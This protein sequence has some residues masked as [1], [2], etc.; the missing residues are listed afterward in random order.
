MPTFVAKGGAGDRFLGPFRFLG[1]L[2][3]LRYPAPRVDR[4]FKDGYTVRL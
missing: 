2:P 1:Y 3:F 4:R